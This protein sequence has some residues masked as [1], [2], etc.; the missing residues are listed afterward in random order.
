V[1]VRGLLFFLALT[2]CLTSTLAC[3][4]ELKIFSVRE[5]SSVFQQIIPDFM[6]SSPF[7]VVVDFSSAGLISER[8]LRE[9]KV[10]LIFVTQDAWR[11]LVKANKFGAAVEIASFGL[12]M[13]MQ[14]G[15]LPP[16][17]S[18][19][20][21][22]KQVL[23]DAKTVGLIGLAAHPGSARLYEFFRR[24]HLLKDLTPKLKVYSSALAL[25]AALT[26]GDLEYG[27]APT[28]NLA[29]AGVP[30]TGELPQD[31]QKQ[32]MVGATVAIASPRE[33]AAQAFIR[34]I[35]TSDSQQALATAGLRPARSINKLSMPQP[36]I[37]RP[38]QDR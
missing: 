8:V 4:D 33:D 10:D 23:T 24:H 32:E 9:E 22:L 26:R 11:P 31:I 7:N 28:I 17:T 25:T 3:A 30:F 1:K 29:E 6:R 5:M 27:F 20:G 16:D 18:D 38:R 35:R 37:E 34:L 2:S 19:I 15:R 13:G 36:A 12:G 14:A 21:G